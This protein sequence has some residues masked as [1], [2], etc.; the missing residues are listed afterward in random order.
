MFIQC[1]CK[2]IY[3]FNCGSKKLNFVKFFLNVNEEDQTISV[4]TI[5]HY[6]F[7]TTA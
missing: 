3:T 4:Q 1:S 6:N 2:F 7:N 5:T